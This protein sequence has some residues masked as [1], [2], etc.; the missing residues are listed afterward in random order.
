MA[1]NHGYGK[2]AGTHALVFAYD[3]GDTRNSYRGE[4]TENLVNTN[5][6]VYTLGNTNFPIA[7][8]VK[9]VFNGSTQ[10]GMSWT[11]H[12][13]WYNETIPSGTTI[14]ISG[15]YMVYNTNS[16][17]AWQTSARLIIYSSAGYGGTV[18]NP[19]AWNTWKYFEV[20]YTVP[21]DTT[22]FRLEDAGYDYYNTED[23]S[24]TT[25]YGCNY[26][27]ELKSHATPFVEGTRSATQGLLDLTGNSSIDLSN[28]SF[29]S[30][31]NIDLDGTDDRMFVGNPPELS[32]HNGV[33]TIEAIVKFPRDWTAGSQYPNLVCKGARAGWDTPGW[34]L[35]GFRDWPNP[36]NKS[37]GLGLRNSSN[38]VRT[39]AKYDSPTDVYL[40]LTATMNGETMKL[41]ENG[42][43][44]STQTQTVIPAENGYNVF[45]GGDDGSNRFPGD[46]PVVK[47]YNESLTESQIQSNFNN[48]RK[49]FSDLSNYYDNAT[50]GGRWIR[51]WWYTGVG[52]PGHE[53]EALGHSFGTFDSSSHYGFQRLPEGLEKEQVELL[54]KDGDGNIYK[55]DFASPSATAQQVWDSF[56]TGAQG[57]W[58]N[59]GDAW[60]PEVIAGSF[61]NT[62]Q[63]AWQYRESEGVVS[64]MLDDDT[65]DCKS[66]LNAGHA[67]CGSSWNQQ[68]AQPDGAYLR[69]G[70]DTLND[71]GCRGPVPERTLELYYRLK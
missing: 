5:S 23:A 9:E 59:S 15:W 63:D 20:T 60:N 24:N 21:S 8:P 58:N 66:T 67:M 47:V 69:Y 33:G 55:W 31:S 62:D 29:D 26:Q 35:F 18:C 68:Y 64:F 1:V 61:F 25:A 36:N 49:R 56:T 3:T 53:P 13:R 32:L 70:V 39:V 54:A 27:L 7:P 37:W 22:S 19:G 57:R 42:V 41:Y 2:M 28:V 48:Y 52:W 11:D 65:C 40:H 46:I 50:D 34:A 16:A 17:T 12:L 51:W 44:V 10:N 43:L 45:I 4:P 6:N 30:S 38:G 71:G 14:T